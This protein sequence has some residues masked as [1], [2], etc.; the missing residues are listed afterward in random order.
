MGEETRQGYKPCRICGHYGSEWREIDATHYAVTAPR[1][2][3]VKKGEEWTC[4]IC[5]DQGHEQ[6]VT[7][8]KKDSTLL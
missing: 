2:V 3:S 7:Q 4:K 6:R 5:V 8:T 1:G